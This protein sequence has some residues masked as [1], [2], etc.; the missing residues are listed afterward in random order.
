MTICHMLTSVQGSEYFE[1]PLDKDIPI[2]EVEMGANPELRSINDP[3]YISILFVSVNV[4]FMK[5][6]RISSGE[7]P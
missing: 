3:M 1:I 2:Q 5:I 7:K 4:P 6:V